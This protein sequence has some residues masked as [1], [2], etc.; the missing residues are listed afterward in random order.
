MFD[1]VGRL[2]HGT[3]ASPSLTMILML[4]RVRWL[5]DSQFLASQ[6]L[7]YGKFLSRNS[8]NCINTNGTLDY[9]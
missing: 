8:V 4:V 2:C 7:A 6:F 5:Q 1:E 3:M 9:C